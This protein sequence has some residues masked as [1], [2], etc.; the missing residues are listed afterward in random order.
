[1]KNQRYWKKTDNMNNIN[2]TSPSRYISDINQSQN[3]TNYN[4]KFALQHQNQSCVTLSM[5]KNQSL[6]QSKLASILLKQHIGGGEPIPD[7]IQ[8]SQDEADD[9]LAYELA[10]PL[11]NAAKA[12]AVGR[13]NE[14]TH[15]SRIHSIVTNDDRIPKPRVAF[16]LEAD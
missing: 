5:S 15:S 3:I 16:D 13:R 10:T 8:E 12:G 6:E 14:S 4:E 7:G 1:M 2:N 11:R 9:E